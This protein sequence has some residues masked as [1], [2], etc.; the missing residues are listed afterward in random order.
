VLKLNVALLD[1][2]EWN[3]VTIRNRGEQLAERVVRLWPGPE[4]AIWNSPQRVGL[5]SQL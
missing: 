3:E 5:S 2:E 1:H 4:T